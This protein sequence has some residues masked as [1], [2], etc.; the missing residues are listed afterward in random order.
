MLVKVYIYITLK[1]TCLRF[2]KTTLYNIYCSNTNGVL[3]IDY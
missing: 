2:R 1:K 3:K